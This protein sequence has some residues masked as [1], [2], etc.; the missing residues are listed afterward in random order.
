MDDEQNFYML[1]VNTRVQVEHPVT[2]MITGIDIVKEMIRVAA[3]EPLSVKQERRQGERPRD[4]VP[5]QRRGSRPRLPAPARARSSEFDVP[6]GPGVRVDTHVRP[7][8][9]I[10][11]NYDS[12]IGKLIVHGANRE[13]A[14]A[15]MQAA[16]AEFDIGPIKTTIPLHRRMMEHREFVRRRV[17]H[18]LRRAN[19][20]RAGGDRR[21]VRCRVR[22]S[23]NIGETSVVL[24]GA[25]RRHTWRPMSG[26]KA[27]R[28]RSRC[29]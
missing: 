17:R 27:T 22:S 13:E 5:D 11:P 18:P 10:P 1:E 7:G 3:G 20:Q 23:L 9:R 4:R 25:A 28:S 2:E 14:I 8:Y 24:E 12:M 26:D 21:L 16:L 6:G 15:R 29:E 19:A